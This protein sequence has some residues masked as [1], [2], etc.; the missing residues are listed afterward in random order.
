[1]TVSG[2]GHVVNNALG[3]GEGGIGGR[4]DSNYLPVVRTFH[5]GL[6]DSDPFDHPQMPWGGAFEYSE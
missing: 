3:R 1:M 2:L 5:C 6:S 4:F